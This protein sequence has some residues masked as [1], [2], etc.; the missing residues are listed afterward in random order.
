MKRLISFFALI[1]I[2]TTS[3]LAYDFMVDGICYNQNSDGTSVTVT[4]Q[5]SSTHRYTSL[6][7]PLDIPSSVT[8]NGKDYSVTSI[9]NMA[10]AGCYDLTSVTI[11]NSITSIGYGAFMGC[12]GLKTVTI[13]KSVSKIGLNPFNACRL[14]TIIVERGNMYYD[15]RNNCNAIIETETNTLVCGCS[16]TIIPNSVTIIANVAFMGLKD[17]E[18]IHIPDSVTSIGKMAFKFCNNLTNLVIPNSVS[19]IG[20]EAFFGCKNLTI[21]IPNSVTEIGQEAFKDCYSVIKSGE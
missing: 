2:M 20:D 1:A 3:A 18:S 16:E 12:R 13:P 19:K 5:N 11:P 14:T 15:S 10:F 6:S 4:S 17:L 7:G 9:D 21:V 8:Y